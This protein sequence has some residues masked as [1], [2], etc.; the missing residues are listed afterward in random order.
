MTVTMGGGGDLLS[1]FPR[2]RRANIPMRPL[3][4]TRDTK[5][6]NSASFFVYILTNRR[7][8]TLYVGVTRDIV[9]RIEEHRS[10]KVAGFTRKHGLHRLVHIENF[11]TALDAITREKQLKRW[12]RRWKL[13]LIEKTNPYWRDL[14]ENL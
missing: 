3:R 6:M 10:G 11:S 8:G 9:R 13:E 14:A 7:N 5:S 1:R 4:E 12:R 2:A